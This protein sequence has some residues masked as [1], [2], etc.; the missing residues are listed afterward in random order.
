MARL[1]VTHHRIRNRTIWLRK[2]Y[3]DR[4]K[5]EGPSTDP[6]PV[7]LWLHNE[8]AR[9]DSSRKWPPESEDTEPAAKKQATGS[10]N[11]GESE[12]EEDDS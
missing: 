8:R 4:S 11:E 1:T 6:I 7:P 10:D 12:E 5:F 3:E 9:W 2:Y